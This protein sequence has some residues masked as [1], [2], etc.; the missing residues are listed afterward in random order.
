MSHRIISIAIASL[1]LTACETTPQIQ[2]GENAEVIQGHLV[3]VDNTN[4]KFVYVDPDAPFEKYTAIMLAPLGVDNVEIIQPTTSSRLP[5]YRNWEL[6]DADKQR[7]QKA[8]QESMLQQLSQ[9]DGFPV[10]QSIGDNVLRISAKLT[11][12]QPNAPKDDSRSRPVGRSKII[13]EGGGKLSV[14]VTFSDSETGEVLA[15]AKDTRSGSSQWGI[16]NS[17]S[18][19]AEV[20]RVFNSWARQIAA[21]LE[22]VHNKDKPVKT[23]D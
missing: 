1:L 18:N 11:R 5:G 15:L 10:V 6:T 16:N 8:F 7:L 22:S 21:Q 14:E 2:T 17:V 23:G 3:R 13:S 20:K 12:I 9:K 19:A 4:A